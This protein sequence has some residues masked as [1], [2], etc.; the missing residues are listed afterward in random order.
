M[1]C[2]CELSDL[3]LAVAARVVMP[4]WFRVCEGSCHCHLPVLTFTQILV[5]YSSCW[6]QELLTTTTTTTTNNE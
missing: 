2:L 4:L 6:L 5:V 1:Y 3:S